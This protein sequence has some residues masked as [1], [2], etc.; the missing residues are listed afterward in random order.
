M[1]KKPPFGRDLAM[2]TASL[3]PVSNVSFVDAV[4]L[5]D[6]PPWDQEYVRL[7]ARAAKEMIERA[8]AERPK[9]SRPPASPRLA[10]KVPPSGPHAR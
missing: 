5:L 7:A 1:L 2:E 8:R 4:V 10:T 6:D 3:R 9:T